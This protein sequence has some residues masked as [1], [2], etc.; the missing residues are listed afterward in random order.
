MDLIISLLPF[1]MFVAAFVALLRGFPV[2]F[3]LAR[4]RF[5]TPPRR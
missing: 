3:T 5:T 4:E 1:A 2:A